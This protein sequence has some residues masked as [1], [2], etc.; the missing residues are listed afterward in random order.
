MKCATTFI[1]E[2][3]RYHPEIFMSSPKEIH[4]FTLNNKNLDWYLSFFK[5][6]SHYKARGEF[7]IG[8]LPNKKVP[9]KIK[10]ELGVVKIIVSIRNPIDRFISHYKHYSR[11]GKVKDKLTLRNYN[12][13]IKKY[14]QLLQYGN[15]YNDI[16]H[17]INNFGEK[18]IYIFIKEDLDEEPIKAIQDL[19][20]FL[21]VDDTFVPPIIGEKVSPGIN[22]KIKAFE[23]LRQKIHHWAF[24]NFPSLIDFVKK[25]KLSELYR[26]I[27]K[28][29]DFFVSKEVKKKLYNYKGE[30]K[31]MEEL[32]N[33]RLYS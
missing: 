20:S 3:L 9:Y 33:R 28:K 12:N 25:T 30:I 19:Y 7:S 18:N 1:S 4:Y 26:D 29:K 27:N 11:E 31:N 5:D 15:Y 14:P 32:L 24:K 8:Y 22:P 16:K 21:N 6:S 23:I 10:K 13:A 17:Y 2:C